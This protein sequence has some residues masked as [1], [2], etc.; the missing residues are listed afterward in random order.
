MIRG[1]HRRR[2]AIAATIAATLL[3]P[4]VGSVAGPQKQLDRNQRQLAEIRHKIEAQS[5]TEEALSRRVNRLNSYLTKLQLQIRRLDEQIKNVESDLRDAQARIDDTQA[6]IDKLETVATAQAVDLY[7]NGGTETL[8][9]LLDSSSL[10]ELDQKAEMIGV[11]AEQTTQELIKYGRLREDIVSLNEAMFEKKAE[12]TEKL[13]DRSV[14]L[15]EHTDKSATYQSDLAELRSRLGI[16]EGKEGDLEAAQAELNQAIE[17]HQAKHAVSVLGTSSQGFIWPLNGSITSYYGPRWGSFHPG[18]DI[19]GVTGQ[20]IVAAK[21][22]RVVLAGSYSGYGNAVVI[23]LGGGYTTVYGHMSAFNTSTGAYVEQGQ[24][25]G[26][27]GCTGYCTG[28][29]L[30]FE[31]RINDQDVD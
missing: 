30:H 20:P 28:D 24:V 1:R 18:I 14:L 3:I 21:E 31:L 12:L 11:A 2:G 15:A 26:Y 8:D 9:A 19:D 17:E 23:D 10:G 5:S 29:H 7:K 6:Q 22:G 27:V 25:I 4:A 16:N 13:D